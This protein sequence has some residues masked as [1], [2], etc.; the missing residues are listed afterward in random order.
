MSNFHKILEEKIKQAQNKKKVITHQS[1]DKRILRGQTVTEKFPILDLGITPNIEEQD[2]KIKIFGLVDHEIEFNLTTLKQKFEEV[3]EVSDFHCVTHWSKLD[4]KWR[5]FRPRDLLILSR[6]SDDAKFVTLHSYDDYT[7]NLPLEAIL[8]EDVLLATSYDNKLL[9]REHGGPVRLVVPK[10]YAWKS[11]K[12]IKSI[13]LHM[14]DRP[15]F[16]EVRGYH[17]EADPWLEQRYSD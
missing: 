7:T 12:W 9:D 4:V 11:A 6:P 10:R 15:G 8:D 2:W 3:E 5:G 17:N 14:E 13:E 1:D 16:W